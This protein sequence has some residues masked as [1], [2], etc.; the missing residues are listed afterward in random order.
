MEQIENTVLAK[1]LNDYLTLHS[2]LKVNSQY[3]TDIYNA[4]NI[5]HSN[6]IEFNI[7]DLAVE[8]RTDVLATIR[9]LLGQQISREIQR[10]NLTEQEFTVSF[11]YDAIDIPNIKHSYLGK[12]VIFSIGFD[13]WH[14]PTIL[15]INDELN[16][17]YNQNNLSL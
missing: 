7:Q 17:E 4:R 6:S 8:D 2:K 11:F 13:E 14:N 10:G 3:K 9:S 1:M 15:S 5:I 12:K 16:P